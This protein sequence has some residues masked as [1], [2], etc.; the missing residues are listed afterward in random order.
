MAL[1]IEP[2][3]VSLPTVGTRSSAAESAQGTGQNIDTG[4]SRDRITL[5][6]G[7][8]ELQSMPSGGES[9]NAERVAQLRSAIESGGYQVNAEQVANGLLRAEHSLGA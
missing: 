7:A 5:T 2:S 6:S 3:L 1:K 4:G 9:F 8:L